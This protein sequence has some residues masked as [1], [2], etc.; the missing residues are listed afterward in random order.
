[1]FPTSGGMTSISCAYLF[2]QQE[3]Q[4]AFCVQ[5]V[6]RLLQQNR[7]QTMSSVIYSEGGYFAGNVNDFKETSTISFG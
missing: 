1:M 5:K 6:D 3:E 2:S 4:I 7:T